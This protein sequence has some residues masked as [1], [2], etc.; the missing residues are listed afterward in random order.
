MRKSESVFRKYTRS[1][2][3]AFPRTIRSAAQKPREE[4]SSSAGP[5]T[6]GCEA[7][8]YALGDSPTKADFIKVYGHTR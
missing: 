6:N 7:R 3:A 2:G 5:L 8:L 1:S 4:R